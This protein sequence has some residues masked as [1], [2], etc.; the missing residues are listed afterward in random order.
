MKKKIVFITKQLEMI[1]L[2]NN[3]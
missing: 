3:R 1:C 2:C